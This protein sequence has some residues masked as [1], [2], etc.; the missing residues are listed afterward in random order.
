MTLFKRKLDKLVMMK[1][2]GILTDE[3]FAEQ[4]NELIA[5]IK[6]K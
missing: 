4:K 6:R 5:E 3:E 1:D 2:A